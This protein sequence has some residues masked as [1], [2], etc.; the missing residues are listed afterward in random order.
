VVAAIVAVSLLDAAGQTETHRRMDRVNQGPDQVAVKGYDPV[1]YHEGWAQKGKPQFVQAYKGVR[2]Q[3]SSEDHLRMF[4]DDPERY[5]PAC[6]GWCATAMLEGKKVDINP[7]RFRKIGGKI[8]LFSG[9]FLGDALKTWDRL[10]E[11]EGEQALAERADARWRRIL[12]Q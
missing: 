9:G 10:A 8:Y 1:G 12:N 7:K 2:Y 11:D 6:G 4:R 5:E 3:F